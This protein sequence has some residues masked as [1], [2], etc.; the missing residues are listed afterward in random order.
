LIA[1][2]VGDLMSAAQ[3]EGICRQLDPGALA[4]MRV[5]HVLDV[6]LKCSRRYSLG[7]HP[8]GRL[9]SLFG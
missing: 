8:T 1:E 7:Q 3:W 6:W 5:T 4:Q 9:S 2:A